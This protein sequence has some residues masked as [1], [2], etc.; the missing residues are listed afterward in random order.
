MYHVLFYWNIPFGDPFVMKEILPPQAYHA[1]RKP[2]VA[3]YR[4]HLKVN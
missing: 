3:T 4:D 2:K 1:L